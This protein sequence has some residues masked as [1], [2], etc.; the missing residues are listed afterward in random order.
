VPERSIASAPTK[1]AELAA[2]RA[3]RDL[4]QSDPGTRHSVTD[5]VLADSSG[6]SALVGGCRLSQPRAGVK[7]I[8]KNAISRCDTC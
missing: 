7:I 6:A 5:V 8:S 3:A 2:E 1:T 4:D